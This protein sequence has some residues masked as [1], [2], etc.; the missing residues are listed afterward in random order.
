MAMARA[1]AL[2]AGEVQR[3]KVAA[4]DTTAHCAHRV[5][6]IAVA[7]LR[8]AAT[9]TA[10]MEQQEVGCARVDWDSVVQAAHH[11]APLRGTEHAASTG[12]A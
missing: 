9:A 11:R 5:L 10:A 4:R 12:H 1:A 8:A 3:A 2:L 7:A 6:Q